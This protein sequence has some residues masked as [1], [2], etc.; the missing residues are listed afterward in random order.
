MERFNGKIRPEQTLEREKIQ[1]ELIRKILEE[2]SDEEWESFLA[3][4]KKAREGE[5]QE[6]E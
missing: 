4:L 5:T 1:D 6:M 2:I 3:K